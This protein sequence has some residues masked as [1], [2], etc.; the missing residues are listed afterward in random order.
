VQ[1]PPPEKLVGDELPLTGGSVGRGQRGLGPFWS[2]ASRLGV[3]P[4]GPGERGTV[5]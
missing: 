3:G 4:G 1:V 5:G 2:W